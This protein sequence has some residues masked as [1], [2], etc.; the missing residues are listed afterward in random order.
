MNLY[1]V[2]GQKLKEDTRITLTANGIFTN[3]NVLTFSNDEFIV[4]WIE[5]DHAVNSKIKM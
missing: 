2:T 5:G 3:P 4:V 1:S